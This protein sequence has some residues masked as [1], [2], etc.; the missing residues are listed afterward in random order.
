MRERLTAS[1]AMP[2]VAWAGL[3]IGVP[4]LL[5][6]LVVSIVQ[7]E[8]VSLASV[9]VGLGASG[10][11]LWHFLRRHRPAKVLKTT[12]FRPFAPL[13][14][15]QT[16]RRKDVGELIEKIEQPN[17]KVPVV[18]GESGV[19]KSTLLNVMVRAKIPPKIAYTVLSARHSTLVDQL[20]E[21][22][23]ECDPAKERTVVVVD[24]FEQWLD[25]IGSKGLG[26]RAEAR[27]DFC[28]IVDEALKR[29]DFTIVISLRRD[30]YF[31]LR[32]LEDRI[33]ALP[34]VF[35]VEAPLADAEKGEEDPM[36]AGIRRSFV[37][38]LD[39]EDLADEILKQLGPT[40]RLLP[41]HAQ[42]VGAVLERKVEAGVNVDLD[43]FNTELGG[44]EGAKNAYFKEVL[45]G[46]A[47]PERC[48][49]VLFALSVKGRFRTRV[50]LSTLVD[51]LYENT[52]AVK[53][54]LAY[55][56]DQ[57]L[58]VNPSSG[59]Y[60]LAHDFLGEF[61]NDLSGS[62]LEPV[63]RD[64]IQ[65]FVAG[66]G[67]HSKVVSTPNRSQ[68]HQRWP[69]GM[70]VF[71]LLM[72]LMTVRFIYFGINWP[73]LGPD[74]ATPLVNDTFF[75][76]SFLLI[77]VPYAGWICYCGLFYDRLLVHLH[78]ST[79]QR[80]LSILIVLNTV[81]S[82]LVGVFIPI[83]WLLGVSTGGVLFALKM[84][85]LSRNPEL[86]SSAQKRLRHYGVPTLVNLLIVGLLGIAGIV[87]SVRFVESGNDSDINWWMAANVVASFMVTYS[88]LILAPRHVSHE[89]VAQMLGLIGRPGS[90][91]NA[92]LED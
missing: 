74:V 82:V 15:D 73:E 2:D 72:A 55:L 16:W 34:E 41:L 26:E 67:E 52:E 56:V 36:R 86:T 80:F 35:E 63:V 53:A 11:L 71:L 42:I 20:R 70:I 23:A 83:A 37:D 40:G 64:N 4:G 85:W 58:V 39:D 62:E 68:G 45:A 61:F 46:S 54:E 92:Y 17:G 19:G 47:R 43:Y 8:W 81:V 79:F 44:A 27:D 59:S 5:A 24:Q 12:V 91:A 31:H 89:S 77:F 6:L 51:S 29:D 13:P 60:A 76:A 57:R 84:L 25:L 28:E 30:W 32:F 38:V 9:A 7:Q 69:F 66:H 22:M 75:D 1:T 87:F 10:T 49:K 48:L 88:C 3:L 90:K 78:E 65:F 33:P 50:K 14:A 21:V 18:V